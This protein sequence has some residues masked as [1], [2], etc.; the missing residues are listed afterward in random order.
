MAIPQF[1]C[2]IF[3]Q[4]DE[5]PVYVSKAEKAE[6]VFRDS[7]SLAVDFEVSRSPT[8]KEESSEPSA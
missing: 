6:V 2:A 3:D 8:F 1:A 4:P 5:R 7:G